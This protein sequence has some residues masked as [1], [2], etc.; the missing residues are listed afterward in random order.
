MGEGL[1]GSQE[2]VRG[3]VD[4]CLYSCILF[5]NKQGSNLWHFLVIIIGPGGLH[6]PPMVPVATNTYFFG[7]GG[8]AC[9]TR[10]GVAMRSWPLLLP[11]FSLSFSFDPLR[12]NSRD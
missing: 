4:V 8:F 6:A 1:E 7:P 9:A 2:G 10:G 12:G 11:S 3:E 5:R